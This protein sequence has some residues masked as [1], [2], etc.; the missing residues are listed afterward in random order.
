MS[1]PPAPAMLS[2]KPSMP[3]LSLSPPN[4]GGIAGVGGGG[5]V[6]E[7]LDAA[8]LGTGELSEVRSGDGSRHTMLELHLASIAELYGDVAK[9]GIAAGRFWIA[10]ARRSASV[11]PM[12]H[13]VYSGTTL[14]CWCW[15]CWG[16]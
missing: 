8:D 4:V 10:M 6:P 9:C 13:A 2:A 11:E 14:A 1:S 5:D 12:V 15:G 7:T 3:T 16:C